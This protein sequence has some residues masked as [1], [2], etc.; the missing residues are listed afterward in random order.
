MSGLP[1]FNYLT[2][3]VSHLPPSDKCHGDYRAI[4][5]LLLKVSK[6]MCDL[7]TGIDFRIAYN[8]QMRLVYNGGFTDQADVDLPP[9]FLERIEGCRQRIV[10]IYLH[11]RVKDWPYAHANLLVIDRTVKT[12]ERFEPSGWFWDTDPDDVISEDIA[13][14]ADQLFPDYT[15]IPAFN[16]CPQAGFRHGLPRHCKEGGYC[17]VLSTLYGHLRLVN[18]DYLQAEV[19]DEMQK[20][21]DSD[22]LFQRRYLSYIESVTAEQ[23][24]RDK[25]ELYYLDY[26]RDQSERRR[27]R[28]VYNTSPFS[29]IGDLRSKA[30]ASSSSAK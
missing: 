27:A 16:Y 2:A 15:Y 18:P 14:V 3:E 8:S 29:R 30:N 25:D 21:L 4:I 10:M 17:V 11:I 24:E 19:I 9:N 6:D 7:M 20:L 13:S 22:P 5:P 23:L 26:L 28:P 1:P 12:I